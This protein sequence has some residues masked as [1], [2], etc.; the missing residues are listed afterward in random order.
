M[1]ELL[2]RN[3]WKYSHTGCSCNGSPRHYKHDNYFDYTIILRNNK[4]SIKK[5]YTII[6]SGSP[7]QLEQKMNDNGIKT[8]NKDLETQ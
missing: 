2:L 5:G 8:E 3:G 4:F 6:A 7:D 1:K